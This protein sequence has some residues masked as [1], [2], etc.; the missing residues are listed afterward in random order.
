[1]TG[2]ATTA[3][4]STAPAATTPASATA[5]TPAILRSLLLGLALASLAWGAVA[6]WT[7]HQHASAASQ[8]VTSSEP[9]SLAAQRMYQA[10]SDADVTATTAFLA[11]PPEPLAVRRHYEADIARAAADLATLR[12][13]GRGPAG[14][15]LGASLAAIS[16]GLPVYAGYVQQAQ[17]YSSLGYPLTGGSF[18]QVASEQMHL[19]LLPAARA[20]YAQENASLAAQSAGATGLPWVAVAVAFA[21]AIAVALVGTQRW[22]RRRT[23]RMV[24]YGLLAGTL[25]VAVAVI[26]LAVA[27]AAARSDLQRGLGHGSGPAEVLARAAIAAQQARGDEVLNLISRSGSTSFQ[28]DFTAMRNAIGPGRGS[29]L[30]AAA[31]AGSP[32]GPGAGAVAR[33]ARDARGWYSVAGQVFRLDLAA[34]YAA[35][36]RLVIGSGPTGSAAGFARLESDLRR[37]IAADQVVFRSGAT[38]GSDSFGGLEAVV[39]AAALVMAAGSAWGLSRRLAEYR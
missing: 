29:L 4:A 14:G 30:A 3:P 17:T 10:L 8:V 35:E 1:V 26:W 38:A 28:Q 20:I 22:L 18:I 34:N 7:V 23:H 13:A 32:S 24:N 6:A 31:A 16:A 21:A 36:T 15:N 11:G 25:A 12:A 9:L 19:T 33:A 37:A 27:F 5:S 2:P 39:A